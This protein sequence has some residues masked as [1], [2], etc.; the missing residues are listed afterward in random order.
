MDARLRV[1]GL[2]AGVINNRRQLVSPYLKAGNYREITV[3]DPAADPHK[4]TP[5][6]IAELLRFA[7]NGAT[8][9]RL[10]VRGV[11]ISHRPGE[12][13]FLREGKPP[14][15]SSRSRPSRSRP[16]IRLR[17]SAFPGW[18]R[19]APSSKTRSIGGPGRDRPAPAPAFR[20]GVAHRAGGTP[21]W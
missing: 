4:L 13:I 8:D 17:P 5:V 14:S 19:S 3:V 18:E 2:A 10:K 21:T 16:A 20:Q 1:R 15:W 9:R 7:P 12:R 11:V 6:S